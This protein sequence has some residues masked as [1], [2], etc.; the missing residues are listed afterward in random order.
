MITPDQSHLTTFTEAVES[1]PVIPLVTVQV[2]DLMDEQQFPE[3]AIARA[4]NRG[5]TPSPEL[6]ARADAFLNRDGER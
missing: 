5:E 4:Y 2:A 1:L 3:M 6:I